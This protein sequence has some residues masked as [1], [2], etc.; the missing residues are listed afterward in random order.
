M[1]RLFQ[2]LRAFSAREL[3]A[4]EKYLHSPAVNSRKDIPLLLQ[5]YR[6]VPKGEP[7]QPE[8]LWRAVHPG[9]PFLL[10]DWRLLLSRT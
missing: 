6:K 7:P 10:R 2:L 3:S 4:L 8:Q 5:A 9:E 1:P